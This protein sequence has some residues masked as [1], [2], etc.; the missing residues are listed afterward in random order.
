MR[1]AIA[2]VIVLASFVAGCGG[3]KSSSGEWKR[4]DVPEGNASILLPPKW[5]VLDDF[6]PETISDFTEENAEFA[7]YVE[8]LIEND[9]FK[10]FAIDPDIRDEFATNVNVI[11]VPVNVPLREWVAQENPATERIAVPGSLQ[12]TFVGTP[13]GEAARS[14]WLLEIQSKGQMRTVRSF[15]FLFRHESN[16]YVFTFSTL[17]EHAARYEATFTRAA[18]SIRFG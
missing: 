10:L 12:S 14:S 18:Q 17:P 2:I 1:R 9:V 8:Q 3:A 11:V 7:P 16:G 5:E 6:D 4:H 15:Q 13:G